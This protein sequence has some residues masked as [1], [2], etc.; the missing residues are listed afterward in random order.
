MKCLLPWKKLASLAAVS[1]A[2]LSL[3][4]NGEAGTARE[5]SL[6][7][8]FLRADGI[9]VPF[10]V[11]EESG[12]RPAKQADTRPVQ[13]WFFYDRNGNTRT[14]A[15]GMLVAPI[16][17]LYDQ[18]GFMTDYAPREVDDCC[19]PVPRVGLL[20]SQKVEVTVFEQLWHRDPW[21]EQAEGPMS[22]ELRRLVELLGPVMERMESEVEDPPTALTSDSGIQLMD[23]LK[24]KGKVLGATIYFVDGYRELETWGYSHLKTWLFERN[25]EIV[26][27]SPSWQ[28]EDSEFKGAEFDDPWGIVRW[29][30]DSFLL[31]ERSG[32]EWTKRLVF[33]VYDS[34]IVE[35][36]L[37]DRS[38][39]AN[40]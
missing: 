2:V 7:G 13:Q 31:L 29:G 30:L 18:W 32:W 10:L 22:D 6:V 1:V 19:F 5:R 12:L 33:E 27:V 38:Q 35:V 3:S 16:A 23:V 4:V 26:V 8:G 20:M 9:G 28:L 39:P 36:G 11:F 17:D 37:G 14:L 40:H 21:D 34:E 24:S 25:N 15:G